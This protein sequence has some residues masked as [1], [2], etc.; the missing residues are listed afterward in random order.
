MRVAF[1]GAAGTGKTSVAKSIVKSAVNDS[2]KYTILG[3]DSRQL[4]SLLGLSQTSQIKTSYYR[5]FQTMYLGQKIILEDNNKK[6]LTERSYADCLAYWRLHCSESATN[7]ENEFIE[8]LCYKN[9][10]KYDFHFF[11]PNGYLK[12]EQDGFRNP[13]LEYHKKYEKELLKIYEEWKIERI[14]MPLTNIKERTRF[15]LDYLS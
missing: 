12:L 10:Y 6:F 1:T 2:L 7:D 5:V 13:S 9:I 15:V 14:E 11:Y 8:S 3:V 4:L